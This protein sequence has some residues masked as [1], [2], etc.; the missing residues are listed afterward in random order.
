MFRYILLLITLFFTFSCGKYGRLYKEENKVKNSN[1]NIINYSN[2]QTG[3]F[4]L[5]D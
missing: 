5:M 4:I 1:E 2:K 3:N